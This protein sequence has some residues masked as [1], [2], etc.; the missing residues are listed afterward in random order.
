M[1]GSKSDTRP[2]TEKQKLNDIA[3][4][5]RMKKYHA[6]SKKIK[7]LKAQQE[8]KEETKKERKPRTKKE[9]KVNEIPSITPLKNN[10]DEFE[11]K[12]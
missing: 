10:L 11:V 1:L 12:I 3:C 5:E 9:K 4:S 8:T 6:E 2:R 7:E